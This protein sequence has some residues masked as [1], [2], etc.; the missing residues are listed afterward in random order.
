M[1]RIAVVDDDEKCLNRVADLVSCILNKLEETEFDIKTFLNGLDLLKQSTKFDL[2]I[3]DIEMSSINGFKLAEK[4]EHTEKDTN[5]TALVYISNYSNYVFSS[6]KYSPM[7]FVRKDFLED[8]LTE[9][10]NT[11]I[12]K[13]NDEFFSFVDKET[14]MQNKIKLSDIAYFM[15]F[16]HD[17]CLYSM[18]T[19]IMHTIK[20]TGN[21]KISLNSYEEQ[22]SSNGFIR[23]HKSYLVNYINIFEIKD[24]KV[25]FPNGATALIANRNIKEFK[26]KYQELVM[27]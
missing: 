11:F 9:A 16:G 3:L 24:N 23:C 19:K 17:I 15:A 5:S 27:R 20:R 22:F 6:F 8:E 14:N 26:L 1:I 12:S 21:S 2:M 4:L 18:K 7:R 13:R 25:I 10:I